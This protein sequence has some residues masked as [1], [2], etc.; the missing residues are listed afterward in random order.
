M[1][2]AEVA[3]Q[4]QTQV[5]T[6]VRTDLAIKVDLMVQDSQVIHQEDQVLVVRDQ[7]LDTTTK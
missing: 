3:Q 5:I 6:A 4:D 1:A 2:V 7:D